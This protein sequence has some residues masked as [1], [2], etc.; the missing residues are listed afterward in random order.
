MTR[1][2]GADTRILIPH[3]RES[4]IG[5]LAC[6]TGQ[7][8]M[9]SRGLGTHIQQIASQLSRRGLQQARTG[10]KVCV[11][12]QFYRCSPSPGLR[13]SGGR[14]ACLQR[15][16]TPFPPRHRRVRTCRPAESPRSNASWPPRSRWIATVR[17]CCNTPRSFCHPDLVFRAQIPTGTADRTPLRHSSS[18]A[19][20]G[21]GRGQ[22]PRACK[23]NRQKDV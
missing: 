11:G 15:N 2:A 16:P 4:K 5:H 1:P 21:R 18:R 20:G 7:R 13:L 10:F 22:R 19:A 3:V 9:P 17:S 23:E 14:R 8:P 12:S 6:A